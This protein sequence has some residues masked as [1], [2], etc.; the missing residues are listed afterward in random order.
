LEEAHIV[1]IKLEGHFIAAYGF[2]LIHEFQLLMVKAVKDVLVFK[3]EPQLA[4]CEVPKDE[5]D[6][7][8]SGLDYLEPIATPFESHAEF[9]EDEGEDLNTQQ[10]SLVPLIS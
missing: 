6:D 3:D 8:S 9:Q 1:A 2:I 5:H 7:H 4:P 10:C